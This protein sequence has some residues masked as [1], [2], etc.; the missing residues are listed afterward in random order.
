LTHRFDI[1]VSYFLRH[2]Y[3]RAASAFRDVV[4]ESPGD[5]RAWAYLG[6]S[7]AH[8]GEAAEAEGALSRAIACC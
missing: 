7:L 1:A 2:E 5:G 6:I 4:K 3:E 8:L